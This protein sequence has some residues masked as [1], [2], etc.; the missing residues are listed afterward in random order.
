MIFIWLWAVLQQCATK[1][2]I[3]N[4]FGVIQMD[5]ISLTGFEEKPE[6]VSYVNAGVYV[7]TQKVIQSIEFDK[8]LD[9]PNLL[10]TCVNKQFQ[11]NCFHIDRF[12]VD[13]GREK[14]LIKLEE[15]LR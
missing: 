14:D 13:V 12:W 5:G 1:H 7:L 9:M 2:I 4:E 15:H 6:Y 10:M 3:K 8:E 11:V